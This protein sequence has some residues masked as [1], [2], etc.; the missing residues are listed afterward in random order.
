MSKDATNKTVFVV[1]YRNNNEN[2][3]TI[4]VFDN[5]EAAEGFLSA[6]LKLYDVAVMDEAPVY[7]H[8]KI[9]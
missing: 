7:S 8:F 3:T 5:R 2:E 4:A 1:S 6:C 9:G